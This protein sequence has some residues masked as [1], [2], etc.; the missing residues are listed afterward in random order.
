MLMIGMNLF[1]PGKVVNGHGLKGSNC[2]LIQ[3]EIHSFFLKAI[4]YR[5]W[6]GERFLPPDVSFTQ[7]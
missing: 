2:P 3:L 5:D 1:A 4:N 7:D 6:D